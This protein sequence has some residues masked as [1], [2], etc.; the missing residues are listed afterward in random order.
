[1]TA[2]CVPRAT[3]A[4]EL[5]YDLASRARAASVPCV[6][7][8]AWRVGATVKS[9]FF[10]NTPSPKIGT[11][12]NFRKIHFDNDPDMVER[13]PFRRTQSGYLARS[14]RGAGDEA[15]AEA[16][17]GWPRAREDPLR[18]R[19]DVRGVFERTVRAVSRVARRNSA[20]N[21]PSPVVRGDDRARR[22]VS[23]APAVVQ[24]HG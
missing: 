10:E 5:M 12:K 8:H 1:M 11:C 23:R 14:A 17:G 19:S 4:F 16:T 9:V 21:S 6:P 24:G 2:P 18:A 15:R 20:A 7:C 22:A 3:T 13:G